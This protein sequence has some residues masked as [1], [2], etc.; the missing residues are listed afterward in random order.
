MAIPRNLSILAQGANSTGVLA[1][2]KGGTGATTATAA[3]NALDGYLTIATSGGTT[4]LTAT[5]AR[6]IT[7]TGTSTQTIQLPDVTT[8]QLGWQYNIVNLSTQAVTINS[9]GGNAFSQTIT[10]GMSARLICIAVTGTTTASWSLD[11]SGSTTRTGFGNIVYSSSP[12]FTTPN[13]GTPSAATL[14]NATGLPLTTGVTGTLPVANGGTGATTFTTNGVLYG[15]TTNAIQ[16]TAQGAANTILVANAGAPSF[17]AA[18]TIGTSVTTPLINGGTAASSTLTLQST[19]GTGTSDAIIFKTGSQVE[20]MR[21][22]TQGD[23]GIGTTNPQVILHVSQDANGIVLNDLYTAGANGPSYMGRKG[24]GTAASPTATLA[25]DNLISL[26]G[27]SYTGSAFTANNIGLIGINA[28]EN[29]TTTAQGTFIYFSTTSDGTTTASERMRITSAGKILF[30]SSVAYNAYGTGNIGRV[31]SHGTAQDGSAFNSFNWSSTGSAS[32][33]VISLSK[34]RSGTIGTHTAVA[35]G[36]DMGWVLF[37]GSD[38]TDFITGA[39]I[40]GE[41]A[42]TVSTGVVPGRLVFETAT[43]TGTLTEAFRI[44]AAQELIVASAGVSTDNGAYNLQCNGTS[45]WGAG[46]YVNGSDARIKEDIAP[47]GSC[48]DIVEQLNPV[49]F[50]YKQ[51][52][53]NDQNIQPGFI[54]QELLT[55]LAGTNYVNGIVQQGPEYYSVAYQSMIPILTKALQEL[56]AEFD[57][58][59]ASHP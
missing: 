31:Q 35:S 50:R 37:N 5:S 42:G 58:Y 14:T 20:V 21:I 15:N 55:A 17:S 33:A 41:C 2:S 9:S 24:R 54:A 56:K 29:Q 36:N 59:K 40:S 53:S 3:A 57:A 26:V 8:L 16:V 6:T 34:S 48:L 27:R 47:I 10:A 32:P 18:P 49:T 28:S 4:T 13:L 51:D 52:W 12:A 43:L 19:S 7:L 1:I 22:D 46:A 39:R 44:N 45:V 23:I 38:G 11:F 25:N 30:G